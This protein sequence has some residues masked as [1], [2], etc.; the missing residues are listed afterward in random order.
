VSSIETSFAGA[1][2][3]REGGFRGSEVEGQGFK[4]RMESL[5]TLSYLN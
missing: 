5:F 2:L 4:D 1:E 3:K